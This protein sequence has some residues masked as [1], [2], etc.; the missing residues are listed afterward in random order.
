MTLS[1]EARADA[2]LPRNAGSGLKLRRDTRRN[3]RRLLAAA[4]EIVKGGEDLTIQKV[5]ERADIAIA[6]AY[7]HFASVEDLVRSY[8]VAVVEDLALFS[9]E[10]ECGGGDLLVDVLGHWVNLVKDHGHVMVNFRSTHGLLERSQSCDPVAAMIET[11]WNRPIQEFI[12][13]RSI[14]AELAPSALFLSNQLFEPREI[15]DML[16]YGRVAEADLQRDLI[17]TFEG[18]L[19]GLEAARYPRK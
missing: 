7:R 15:I 18:A 1:D 16:D 6:T 17:A 13:H 14:R 12:E 2:Q 10:S 19:R 3:R 9:A 8:V 5:A 4:S 11:A